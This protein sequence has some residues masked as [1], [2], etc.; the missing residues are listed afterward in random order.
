[1]SLPETKFLWLNSAGYLHETHE[2]PDTSSDDVLAVFSKPDDGAGRVS[3]LVYLHLLPVKPSVLA[4][5]IAEYKPT[6]NDI[7]DYMG[8]TRPNSIR[9]YGLQQ[10]AESIGVTLQ[11]IADLLDERIR[12]ERGEDKSILDRAV[13]SL[14]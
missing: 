13:P 6:A 8:E 7:V 12:Q 4:A 11:Q 14:N 5:K 2:M 9:S 3:I 10:L 1:M